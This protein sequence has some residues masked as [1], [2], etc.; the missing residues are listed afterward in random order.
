MKRIVITGATGGIGRCLAAGF[1]AHGY[2]V[3]A[4]DL[5]SAVF[6]APSIRALQ[7]DLNDGESIDRAFRRIVLAHGEIHALINNAAISRFCK[8]VS[9]LPPEDFERVIRTNLIGSFRCSKAFIAQHSP[10]T[11]GR[12]VNIASTRF[13]Q[14]EAG[15]DAYGASKG[16]LVALTNSLCVSLSGTGIT[17][18]AVSPGWIETG[19]YSALS[20]ADHRQHPSGRVGRP[21]DILNA[22]LFLCDPANGFVNGANLL[23]DGGMTKRMIYPSDFNVGL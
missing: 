20:D 8:P 23:I 12:I 15:W 11:Y 18:N 14:N 17:V 10:G 5:E 16:G 3:F 6:D 4:V 13:C 1:A 7:V 9:A 2:E 22:C 21:E 19:D